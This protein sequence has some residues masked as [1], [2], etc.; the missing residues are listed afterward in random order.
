MHDLMISQS[1]PT[2]SL[3]GAAGPGPG[4][5]AR[6]YLLILQGDSS[7]VFDLPEEGVILIGRGDEVDLSL[8]DAAV[9]R[10]H[11]RLVL[12]AGDEARVVDL[13]SHNGTFVNGE[14]IDGAR[15]LASGDVVNIC[16]AT[17]VLH[18]GRSPQPERALLDSPSLRRRFEEERARSVAYGGPLAVAC[19]RVTGGGQSGTDGT[20][21]IERID[22]IAVARAVLAQVRL[23]DVVG[24][25][26]AGDLVLLLPELDVEAASDVVLAVLEALGRGGLVVRAGLAV[27][28][29]DG[30]DVDT[31]L[32]VARAAAERAAPGQLAAGLHVIDRL[33]I[34]D[35]TV[36][37]A[38]PAMA[39]AYA[40]LRRLAASDLAL[41]LLGETGVGKENAAF[42]GHA[43]SPRRDGPFVTVNCA[44]I[45]ESLFESELFGY[46]RGA[47][48]G[49][50]Q[51]KAGLLEAASGGTLF[52]DEVGELPAAAQAKLL[53]VLEVGKLTRLGDLRER[54]VN[55]R[56]VAATNRDLEQEVLAGRF[57][58][59]LY[60]RLGA[61]TIILPPLRDR[62]REIPLLAREFL[63]SARA[64]LQRPAAAISPAALERLTTHEW[65]GNVRELKNTME[66]AAAT[67]SDGLVEPWHLPP[68]LAGVAAQ[69]S[70]AQPTPEPRFRPIGEEI[71]E[72]ERRRI[73]EALAAAAGVQTRAAE[74]ISMSLRTFQQRLKDY[75]ITRRRA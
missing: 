70:P 72:L 53:R 60:F 50:V 37:V 66:Y 46:E 29:V 41:L 27:V 20:D 3:G 64:R 1:S 11:A 33:Q 12:A 42:A 51:A 68:R 26:L 31:L 18:R 15:V 48:S 17:L 25:D 69:P 49:A 67:A 23:I 6:G 58:R 40:L 43:W 38:D 34:G 47:F 52:L 55:L 71:E 2:M 35:R 73:G 21:R 54:P 7:S 61:A 22:R 39:A 24:L 8:V 4:P 28:G 30:S 32:G 36:L 10:R 16:G 65:S 56:L 19:L 62:P 75:G 5:G 63:A 74:L 57:R 13:D 59:D 45:P 9:S 44:A 14:R